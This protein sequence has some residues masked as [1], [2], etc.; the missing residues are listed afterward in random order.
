M[1][2][3]NLIAYLVEKG[4]SPPRAD[5]Y[6]RRFSKLPTLRDALVR[7]VVGEQ[8]TLSVRGHTLTKLMEDRGVTEVG[9]ILLMLALAEN[10]EKGESLLN[11][12]VDQVSIE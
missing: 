8:V 5:G 3:K 11:M 10:K 6:V 4:V 2:D 7:L 9:A 12:K 1:D